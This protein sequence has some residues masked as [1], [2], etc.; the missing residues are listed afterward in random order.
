MYAVDPAGQV[1]T[2]AQPALPTGGDIAVES[3]GFVPPRAAVAY[4]A[5]R[6]SAGNKH[7]GDNAILRPSAAQLA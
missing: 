7:P 6:F 1:I 2:L 3:T 4:L 5:D